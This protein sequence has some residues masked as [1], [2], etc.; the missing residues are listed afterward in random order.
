LKRKIGSGAQS[1]LTHEEKD[2]LEK[3]I[4]ENEYI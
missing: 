3:I 2:E 4:I 1:K